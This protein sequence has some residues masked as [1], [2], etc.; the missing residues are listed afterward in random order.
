MTMTF[1]FTA[2]RR[3]VSKRELRIV[4]EKY[5]I[6]ACTLAIE[7]GK[8]GYE[9]FQGRIT[10]AGHEKDDVFARIHDLSPQTHVE[11]AETTD[12]RYERKDGRF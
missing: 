6:K 1:I 5:D 7:K 4:W 8:G 11:V 9:H 2:P 3:Y 10:I 12:N